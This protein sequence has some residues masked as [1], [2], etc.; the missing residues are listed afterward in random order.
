M[1]P[2]PT[3]RRLEIAVVVALL[4]LGLG[5]RLAMCRDYV[6]AGS[7]SYGYIKLADEWRAHGRYA[8]G[9]EP[10]PLHY[11]RPPLYSGFIALVKG[12]ARAEMSGGDFVRN[13]KQ[14]IDLLRQLGDLAP[15]P[16]TAAACRSAA[17]RI[18]RG[19]VSASSVIATDEAAIEHGLHEDL[20]LDEDRAR[21]WTF[22]P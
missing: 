1:P 7:D 8:L 20:P 2:P 10:E 11:A 17:D 21:T 9:P 6:F 4:G 14:L 13:I 16:D 15:S 18:F 12:S 5:L 3:R 22:G 19:V